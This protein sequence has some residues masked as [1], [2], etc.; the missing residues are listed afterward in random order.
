L[1]GGV[2]NDDVP[3]YQDTEVYN[4]RMREQQR[5]ERNLGVLATKREAMERVARS[6]VGLWS[7]YGMAAVRDK[8]WVRSTAAPPPPSPLACTSSSSSPHH[9]SRAENARAHST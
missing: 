2:W 5:A 8:F 9:L 3:P 4:R 6:K 7:N 1:C